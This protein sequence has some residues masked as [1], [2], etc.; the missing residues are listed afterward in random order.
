M[1]IGLS[2]VSSLLFCE[3]LSVDIALLGRCSYLGILFLHDSL[4]YFT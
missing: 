4:F 1:T 3:E 2:W